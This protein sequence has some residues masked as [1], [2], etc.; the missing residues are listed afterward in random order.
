MKVTSWI[1]KYKT[2]KSNHLRHFDIGWCNGDRM[3]K[4]EALEKFSKNATT[5]KR[6]EIV[7]M[8]E[9]EMFL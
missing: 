1:I 6:H 4:E 3:T 9:K 8:Y 2:E 7:D 5:P